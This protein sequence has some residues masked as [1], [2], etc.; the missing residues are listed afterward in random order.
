MV[1]LKRMRSIAFGG[2]RA[3]APTE[4]R[5]PPNRIA[6]GAA[7]AGQRGEETVGT[8]PAAGSLPSSLQPFTRPNKPGGGVAL[9]SSFGWRTAAVRRGSDS[10]RLSSVGFLRSGNFPASNPQRLRGLTSVYASSVEEKS[11]FLFP[12]DLTLLFT[13]TIPKNV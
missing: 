2:R 4:G 8:G 5:Y 9:A 10:R 13:S 6:Y 3:P 1:T 7:A 11:C 12:S